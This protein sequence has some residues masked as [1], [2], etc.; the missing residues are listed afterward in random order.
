[1]PDIR[2]WAQIVAHFLRPGGFLYLAEQHPAAFVFE[3]G[4]GAPADRPG[5]LVPYFHEGPFLLDDVPDY[6]N[7]DAPVQN[8]REHVFPHTLGSIVTALLD[9]G[10]A[11]DYLHEHDSITWRMFGCLQPD[12]R[13][14]YRWPDQPWL[15]LAFSL[16]ARKT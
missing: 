16:A 13:G 8:K 6:M 15:P 14:G 4:P 1:L 9:A 2:R 10:L 7:P 11:L 3:D 5:F 12:G